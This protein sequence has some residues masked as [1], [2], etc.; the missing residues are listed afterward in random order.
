MW[1]EQRRFTF[2]HLKDFGFGRAAQEV[3]MRDE[4]VE[5]MADID[6]QARSHPRGI[7]D[8]K[9]IFNVSVINILLAMVGGKRFRRDDAKFLKLLATIDEIF[10]A[11]QSVRGIIEVPAFLLRVCPFLRDYL[12]KRED[13]VDNMI[14]FVE[15]NSIEFKVISTAEKKPGILRDRTDRFWEFG[16]KSNTK[17]AYGVIWRDPLCSCEAHRISAW[18]ENLLVLSLTLS[19]TRG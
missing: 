16:F 11:G 2:R 4:I 5:L 14:Q 8:I 13:L 10:R 19:Y 18:G 15:V 6:R 17:F 7:V 9:T 3:M 1:R 12:G